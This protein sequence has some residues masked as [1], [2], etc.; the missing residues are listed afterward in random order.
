[1]DTGTWLPGGTVAWAM[2]SRDET[3]ATKITTADMA[4]NTVTAVHTET[5][6]E[7]LRAEETVLETIYPLHPAN[8]TTTSLLARLANHQDQGLLLNKPGLGVNKGSQ[9]LGKGDRDPAGL[10]QL[11]VTVVSAL[12]TNVSLTMNLVRVGLQEVTPATDKPVSSVL[13]RWKLPAH[14]CHEIIKV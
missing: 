13:E 9:S 2:V 1:M 12:P 3:G 7:D 6:P 10:Q 8:I 14:S 4:I 11:T 5:T